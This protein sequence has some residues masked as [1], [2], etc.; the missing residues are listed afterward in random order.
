MI[1]SPMPLRLSRL[2]RRWLTATLCAAALQSPAGAQ[3]SPTAENATPA[4]TPVGWSGGGYY[5]SAAFHPTRDGVLFLGMDVAGVAK[6]TD[7]GKTFRVVNKGLVDYGMYSLAVDV[8]NPDIAYAGTEGGLHKSTDGGESWRFI[9]RT[10]KKDLHI[11]SERNK[12]I[13]SVA[14]DPS[15]GNIVYAASPGGKIYK[16]TDG[17]ATWR[18]VYQKG[19]EPADDFGG[20]RVQYGK[21]NGAYFGG[22]WLS[23]QPPAGATQ[24]TGLG[25]RLKGDGTSPEQAY[26]SV[27]TR[28]GLIYRTRNIAELFADATPRDVVF[29]AQDFSLDPEVAKKSPEKA[30]AAPKQ[31][32]LAALVRMD[33]SRVSKPDEASVLQLG[34]LFFVAKGADGKTGQHVARDFDADKRAQT[35]GNIRLGNRQPD[36]G[37]AYS[38]VVSTKNPKL[39][40]AGTDYA[41]LLLSEDKGETWR[42]LPTPPKALHAAFDPSNPDIIYGTFGADGVHK[43]VDRGATWTKIVNGMSAKFSAREIVVSPANP[44]ELGVIGADGWN[45]GFYYSVDG[46]A[47]WTRSAKIKADYVA[48]PTLPKDGALANLSVPTNLTINPRN[49]KELYISANWRPA[50]SADGGRSWEERVAGADITVQTDIRFSGDRVYVS[51]MDEGTLMS[52]DQG[53]TWKALWPIKYD[54]ELS[55]HNWRLAVTNINGVDRIIAT[56]SPWDGKNTQQ[57]IISEDGG[58]TFKVTTEGLP[59]YRITANTM[60]D[61]GYP[62]ALAVDPLN[63]R[64]VYL[65][66]DGDPTD[67]KQGGGIFKSTDGGYTWKQLPNQPGSRRVYY[68]LAIDPTNPRRIIWGASGKGGGVYVSEDGGDSWTHTLKQDAWIFNVHATADG[69][70]YVGGKDLWRSA[71]QG[72]TWKKL[73]SLTGRSV[74]GIEVDPR[75]PKTIWISAVTWDG[76]SNGDVYKSTDGGATWTDFTGD[77]MHR[78]PQLLRFNPKTNELWSGQTM[79]HKLRQ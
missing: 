73:T 48:N 19:A 47:T 23:F 37:V 69:E 55:G 43:S 9:P 3:N 75:D 7:H 26:L 39:V 21:V 2:V 29:A 72:K 62:R 13:R 25:L 35:Y 76:S 74:V 45:G 59:T 24:P 36:G 31:P 34:R 58:K 12:S 44:Q 65:G 4:W 64:I 17:A 50:Y 52:E 57:V 10:G 30:A 15:D 49:P 1:I 40:L 16:S 66:I 20:L 38:V 8:K 6:S 70:L 79:L 61:R 56:S 51:A 41:G 5:F 60:W 53:K 42:V 68:G 46:G 54:R 78:K 77:L 33:L 63:P 27:R 32:D 22:V 14:P 67:G 18:V 71:D 11:T 28:D